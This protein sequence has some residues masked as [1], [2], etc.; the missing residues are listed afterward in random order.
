MRYLILVLI[1]LFAIFSCK[2][3][4]VTPQDS[5][6]VIP[7]DSTDVNPQEHIFG[8][9]PRAIRVYKSIDSVS[10]EFLYE[11]YTDSFFVYRSR[12][13][14][15]ELDPSQGEIIAGNGD[16]IYQDIFGNMDQYVWAYLRKNTER[17][18]LKR[19]GFFYALHHY[20]DSV[21]SSFGED[22][23]FNPSLETISINRSSS[24]KIR[25]TF[26]TMPNPFVFLKNPILAEISFAEYRYSTGHYVWLGYEVPFILGS[27]NLSVEK[28]YMNMKKISITHE[29]ESHGFPAQSVYD[30]TH[31]YSGRKEESFILYF[32][33]DF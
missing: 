29:Y 31:I 28:N 7:G 22:S 2:K 12:F 4:E 17:N 32:E 33:Y 9:K 13:R 6:K 19:G 14:L 25:R 8:A 15:V 3:E 23:F 18:L 1:T 16:S 30:I 11:F 10:R 5:I 21:E 26:D 27:H 20:W 24:Y